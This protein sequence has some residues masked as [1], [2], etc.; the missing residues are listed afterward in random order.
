MSQEIKLYSIRALSVEPTEEAI[1]EMSAQNGLLDKNP[2]TNVVSFGAGHW[3]KGARH[4]SW[5]FA[6]KHGALFA[7]VQVSSDDVQYPDW[8]LDEASSETVMKMIVKWADA[9]EGKKVP[10]VKNGW[11]KNVTVD[12]VY[13]LSEIDDSR[14]V[15]E[16]GVAV[17]F[18]DKWLR[19]TE[20]GEAS[21]KTCNEEIVA[22]LVDFLCREQPAFLAEYNE[23][24][25]KTVL[26]QAEDNNTLAYAGDK[27][28]PIF[29]L[30]QLKSVRDGQLFTVVQETPLPIPATPLMRHKAG[31]KMIQKSAQNDSVNTLAD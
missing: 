26:G 5:D 13:D 8:R 18:D 14:Q 16:L 23:A 22:Q 29:S 17:S 27:N 28:L 12:T 15:E 1:R 21:K 20:I 2:R 24:L 25:Q 4:A 9:L 11:V 31:Q 30:K 6:G 19:M 10:L 3:G 7:G